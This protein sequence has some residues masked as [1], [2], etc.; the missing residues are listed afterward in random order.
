M[1]PVNMKP[2]FL[3]HI[4]TRRS[5]FFVGPSVPVSDKNLLTNTDEIRDKLRM[6][7]M[8]IYSIKKL[9]EKKN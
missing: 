2:L 1:D 9:Q 7:G 5:C 4:Y 6:D 3:V 8:Y